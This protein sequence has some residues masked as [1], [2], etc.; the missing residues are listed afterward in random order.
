MRDK[1]KSK[2]I[3]LTDFIRY[4][5]DKMKG[6]ERNAFERELQKDPFAEE[7]A[8]GFK[9]ITTEKAVDDMTG[10]NRRLQRRTGK[11]THYLFYRIAAAVTVIVVISSILVITRYKKQPVTLSQNISLETKA[12]VPVPEREE[13][14]TSGADIS[15]RKHAV[16]L[17]L[18][19]KSEGRTQE[20]AA[21]EENVSEFKDAEEKDPAAPIS[22]PAIN[23]DITAAES[24]PAGGKRMESARGA[25]IA[26][27][28]KIEKD[29]DY[30]PPEPV[31]G[32]D[33]FNYYV[34][35][36]I[37]NPEPDGKTPEVVTLSFLVF[38]DSTIS[39][40]KII[41]SP[42]EEY[43][44]EAI[45]LIKGGPAWIPARENNRIVEDSVRVRIVFK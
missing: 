3:S 31:E 6:E 44:L 22:D 42:G 10:L 27:K 4:H 35:T 18:P 7:A 40:I 11:G 19:A 21:P 45:R 28:G 26:L 38:G 2:K 14:K 24:I 34:E 36:N 20:K 8:E 23:A 43:S 29:G 41:S 13:D 25:G 32:R 12:P 9:L 39:E 16:S 5:D 17:P 15:E 30:Q 37:R 1:N 33:T